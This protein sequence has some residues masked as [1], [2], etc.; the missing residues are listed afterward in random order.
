MIY[1]QRYLERYVPYFQNPV[2][3]TDSRVYD[4]EYAGLGHLSCLSRST[5]FFPIE[6]TSSFRP[7][8]A[9]LLVQPLPA[10]FFACMPVDRSGRWALVSDSFYQSCLR[11]ISIDKIVVA[12]GD[13]PSSNRIMV[14]SPDSQQARICELCAEGIKNLHVPCQQSK[15][16]YQPYS[17][18]ALFSALQAFPRVF[19]C[20]C[21]NFLSSVFVIVTMSGYYCT[22]ALTDCRLF[23]RQST[24]SVVELYVAAAAAAPS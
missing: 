17:K 24:S 11:S 10:F 14:Q 18:S 2:E 8:L 5:A 4:A 16:Y 6:W 3:H 19:L 22:K 1:D 12:A 20:S 15:C 23:I 21:L 9:V 13:S 7:V